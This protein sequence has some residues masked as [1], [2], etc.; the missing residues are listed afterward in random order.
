MVS[1]RLPDM[2]FYWRTRE[3]DIVAADDPPQ[4]MP[5]EF[6]FQAEHGLV[7]EQRS[8]VLRRT[9]DDVYRREANVGFLQEGNVLAKSYGEDFLAFLL[10]V[11]AEFPARNVLEIGCG[12]C[13][14]LDRIRRT[15]R[16][17]LGVDPSPVAGAAGRQLGIPVL[18][19]FFPPLHLPMEPDLIL[20][21]D[22]L[23]HIEDPVAFLRTQHD[24]LPVDGGLVV[25][26]PDSTRCIAVGDISMALH[27]H[28]NMFDDRSL[29]SVLWTA[30]FQPLRMRRSNFGGSLYCLAK[31]TSR[32][33]L[34]LQVNDV[35]YY[36]QFARLAKANIAAFRRRVDAARS[37]GTVGFF[38]PQRAFPY[39][40][41]IGWLG[42][43]RIFDNMNV[44]HC[45][46]LD[47]CDVRVENEA[48]LVSS[49]VDHVF[50]MSLTFG[51]EVKRSIAAKLPDIRVTTLAEILDENAPSPEPIGMQDG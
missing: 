17:V 32:P 45:R 51:V 18:Q 24:A 28:V 6:A 33:N 36:E 48:D 15:G 38:M 50:V 19:E 5:F 4:R 47:G 2:P 11:L 29:S 21:V 8:D 49:P 23:E 31:K 35:A 9:L 13:W 22:V 7:I 26:V 39:L 34:D 30:G 16:D 37:R 43:F 41:A 1:I 20:H 44:W 10:E 42:G 27:Q 46:Y 25:N 12:G 40:A 3:T 14:L